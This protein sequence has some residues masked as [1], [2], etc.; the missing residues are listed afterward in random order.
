MLVEHGFGDT[1]GVG[2]VVHRSAVEAVAGEHLEGD[3]EDLF[4]ARG[5][6]QSG[7][8]AGLGMVT[9]G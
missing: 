3:V 9:R 7:A 5:R 1:G 8:G 2:D 6:G 4:P